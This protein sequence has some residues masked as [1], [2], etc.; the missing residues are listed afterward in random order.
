MMER[1]KY[2]QKKS[3][4]SQK[5]YIELKHDIYNNLIR[6]GDCLSENLIASELNMSRTPVREALRMLENEGLVEIKDGI[7]VYVKSISLTDIEDI[8]EVR[9]VLETLA[10][11]TSIYRITDEEIC[12]LEMKF[13]KLLEEFNN[14]VNV[15][16]SSF[17]SVDWQLDELIVN[18]CQNN[19]IISIMNDIKAK[20]IRYQY[21]SH[22][23]LNDVEESTAQHLNIL[24]LIRSRNLKELIEA[25]EKHIDW[26][27]ACFT[28]NK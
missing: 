14:G 9:K 27:F 12:D 15:P 20:I 8:F 1:V 17:V 5:A 7:G 11:K 22:E 2:V 21:M 13:K 10:F 6:P 16:M 25:N 28:Y 4:L 26:A 23:A 18:K 3:S 24:S 19:Y